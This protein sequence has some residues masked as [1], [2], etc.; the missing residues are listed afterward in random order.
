MEQGY[1]LV[2]IQQE[3]WS[4]SFNGVKARAESFPNSFYF[5]LQEFAFLIMEMTKQARHGTF[6]LTK[7][8]AYTALLLHFRTKHVARNA[9]VA[10]NP[11]R[12]VLPK[13]R[14]V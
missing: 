10:T 13:R 4:Y 2:I 11:C 1:I 9:N 14:A 12:I 6:G 5:I 3:V 8:L 7:T